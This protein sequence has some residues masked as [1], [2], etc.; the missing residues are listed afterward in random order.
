[1]DFYQIGYG[2]Q[3]KVIESAISNLTSCVAADI[4]CD[5]LVSKELLTIQTYQFQV[6]KVSDV[7]SLLNQ[8]KN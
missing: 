2:K 8:Q 3:G 1:M 6:G 4:S 7:M 5:K